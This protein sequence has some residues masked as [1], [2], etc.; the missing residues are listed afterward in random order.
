M[1]I[2]RIRRLVQAQ[3]LNA[4]RTYAITNRLNGTEPNSAP[5][6]FSVSFII[7]P[8]MDRR[9]CALTTNSDPMVNEP[10]TPPFIGT[11]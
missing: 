11:A 3:S 1:R 5:A 4:T 9:Y 6:P 7:Y 10:L 2:E 8:P